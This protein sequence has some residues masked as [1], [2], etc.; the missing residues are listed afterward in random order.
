MLFMNAFQTAAPRAWGIPDGGLDRARSLGSPLI[1]LKTKMS[2]ESMFFSIITPLS[3]LLYNN[4]QPHSS[5]RPAP[6]NHAWRSCGGSGLVPPALRVSLSQSRQPSKHK[7]KTRRSPP[8][9]V[10]PEE[11]LLERSARVGFSNGGGRVWTY[12]IRHGP[13]VGRAN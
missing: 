5:A 8:L 2:Y 10:C 7:K 3:L 13:Q 9:G 11:R 6:P 1:Q 12:F 4:K